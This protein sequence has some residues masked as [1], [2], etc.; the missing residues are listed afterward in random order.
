MKFKR[1]GWAKKSVI[2]QINKG[3]NFRIAN[4]HPEQIYNG[5]IDFAAKYEIP[6]SNPELF[7]FREIK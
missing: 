5:L 6:I 4:F 1:V 7:N 3:F 2:V